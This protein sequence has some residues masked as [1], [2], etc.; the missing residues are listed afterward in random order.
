MP[1]SLHIIRKDKAG[2]AHPITLDE[3]KAALATYD[4][5]RLCDGDAQAINPLTGEIISMP[6]RGGDAEIWRPDCEDWLRVFWYSPD[7]FISFPA[8]EDGDKD[9]LHGL[10]LARSLALK[11]DAK[12][13]NDEGV[14]TD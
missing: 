8:P 14:E 12:I 5:L 1:S 7:G 2:E 10:S 4:D 3:W 13:Y 6:N 11:L 9:Q